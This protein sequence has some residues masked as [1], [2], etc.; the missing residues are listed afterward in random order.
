MRNVL[1]TD[2]LHLHPLAVAN[3]AALHA[4]WTDVNVRRF[5]WDGQIIPREQTSD[6]IDTSAQ[7]YR[8]RG[9]GLW[10][11]HPREC[12]ELIGIGGF[13]FFR[14]PPDL[15]L[16]YAVAADQWNRGYATEIARA[17]VAYGLEHLCMTEIRAST[18]AANVASVRVLEKA[19]FQF[20]RRAVTGGLNT[21]YYRLS[22]EDTQTTRSAR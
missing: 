16:L 9:L 20:E 19:G 11:A 4:L 18:D 2:R 12:D 22:R 1:T 7:L 21:V 5:L 13:W 15:E 3:A 10:A 17:V 8:E 14:D 6:I